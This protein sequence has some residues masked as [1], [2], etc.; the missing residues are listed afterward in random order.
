MVHQEQGALMDEQSEINWELTT[1]EGSRREQLRRWC[2][3]TIR[4]RLQAVDDM[5]ELARRIQAMPK[6]DGPHPE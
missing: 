6:K 3:L 1:W 5:G 2:A 4:E